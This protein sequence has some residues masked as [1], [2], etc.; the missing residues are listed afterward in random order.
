M[1]TY[2]Q[3]GWISKA[4]CYQKKWQS[5][6]GAQC[7]IPLKWRSFKDITGVQ[8]RDFQVSGFGEGCTY[9][10]DCFCGDGNVL[11]SDYGGDYTNLNV[12]V[13]IELYA[14]RRMGACKSCWNQNV[15]C[16]T[17][18]SLVLRWFYGYIGCC[19]WGKLG[20]SLYYFLKLLCEPKIISKLEINK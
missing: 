18:N 1:N 10:G 12:T 5:C 3:L 2:A 13:F 19:L 7:V 14:Q 15:S 4:L 8:I 9:D 20:D 17:V 16:T 11:Y 6:K